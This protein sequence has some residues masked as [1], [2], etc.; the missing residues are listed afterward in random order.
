M[1]MHELL[2]LY[3][4]GARDVVDLSHEGSELPQHLRLADTLRY[5]RYDLVDAEK[6]DLGPDT[7]LLILLGPSAPAYADPDDLLPVLR[8]LQPGARAIVL[9]GWPIE[10]LPYHRLLGPFVDSCCQVVEAVPLERAAIHGGLHCA[11]V[12]DCV[13]KLAPLRSYLTDVQTEPSQGFETTDTLRTMLRVVNEYVLSDLVARPLRRRLTE[14]ENASAERAAAVKRVAELE[15]KLAKAESQLDALRSSATLQ[16]G[17]AVVQGI[18]HPVRGFVSVPRDLA[19]VWRGRSAGR[20]V[21]PSATV[22]PTPE[23][24]SPGSLPA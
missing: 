21:A 4:G 8:R 14:L 2:P 1:R 17:R 22:A 20:P 13:D 6:L 3:L 16:V 24:P 11:L 7:L 10:E 12:V 23:A 5:G 19:R 9:T 15:R 18:R